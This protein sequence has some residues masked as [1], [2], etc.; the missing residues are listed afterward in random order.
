M[1]LAP[2]PPPLVRR[3][4]SGSSSSITTTCGPCISLRAPLPL[5]TRYLV[6]LCT[7]YLVVNHFGH[8]WL[9]VHGIYRALLGVSAKGLSLQCSWTRIEKNQIDESNPYVIGFKQKWIDPI[10]YYL[11][12]LC[13]TL[14]TLATVYTI[15][16][17][18]CIYIY[19]YIHL[20]VHTSMCIY[21]YVYI[22]LCIYTSMCIYIHVPVIP[23]L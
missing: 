19:V 1:V 3:V 18:M 10:H 23:C 15:Y 11:W 16:T 4:S 14:G 2:S 12:S 5:C 13:L 17:S 20:C 8:H 7:R 22:H 9:C 21:I 6:P